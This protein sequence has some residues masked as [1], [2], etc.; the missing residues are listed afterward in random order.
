[1]RNTAVVLEPT[2]LWQLRSFG[3]WLPRH[4]PLVNSITAT[5]ADIGNVEGNR[6]P[7]ESHLEAAQQLLQQALQAAAT[8][9][10]SGNAALGSAAALV[11]QRTSAASAAEAEQPAAAV[12]AS[13]H[14]SGTN[15]H[16][17]RQEQRGWRLAS[18][19]S[20]LPGAPALLHV[21]PG[22]S[23]THLHF[24]LQP[25]AAAERALAGLTQLA[26][27]SSLQQLDLK[28]SCAMHAM[29]DGCLAGLA[30][31][32][33]LTS[34]KV[35]GAWNGVFKQ[36]QQ[37][38][39][40]PLPLRKLVQYGVDISDEDSDTPSALPSLA[41]LTQLT[42]VVS[43]NC[44]A[45]ELLLQLPSSLCSLR[46]SRVTDPAPI[47]ALQ[48]LQCLSLYPAFREQSQVLELAQLP[49]L[50]ALELVYRE[51]KVVAAAAPTWALLP[52]LQDI[53]LLCQ[54]WADEQQMA[55]ILAGAAAATQLQWL[56][57]NRAS[58]LAAHRHGTMIQWCC[59]QGA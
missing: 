34:L 14:Q 9:S 57:P 25:G 28:S 15:Q 41:H 48:Q 29:P 35:T 33:G 27:L 46:V 13:T 18:F 26:G 12:T 7:E 6:E 23:L 24:N 37:L 56:G 59:K 50:T 20:N 22:H 11:P 40:Q 39:A 21:L 44:M 51:V 45:D 58:Q 4:A 1:V 17:Q 54:G 38:L 31:L 52:P 2:K 53:D 30:Q 36:L 19:S 32:S 8:V 5:A 16:Q 55:A 3:Q 49:R 43:R 42:E 10:T 47:L